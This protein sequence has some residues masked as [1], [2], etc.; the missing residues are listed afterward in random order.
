SSR[1]TGAESSREAATVFE[2]NHPDILFINPALL[3]LPF[4]QKVRAYRVSNPDLR[5]FQ[6]GPS[7]GDFPKEL[8]DARFEEERSFTDFQRLMTE[9]LPL[10]RTLRILVID[11]EPDIGTMVREFLERRVQPAFE[12]DYA[13]NGREGLDK[14]NR[15]RP[16]VLILDIK[17]PVK[18]GRQVYRELIEKEIKVPAI[19][20]F[21]A[22]SGDEV[23]EIRKIGNPAIVEKGSRQ[24]RLP[25]LLGLIK[26]KAYFG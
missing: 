3:S 8:F 19:I 21:D 13:A 23:T 7:V 22:I 1:L 12:V 4:T 26:K 5:V 25:E 18:D 15:R 20:F 9:H 11:D 6:I 2:K 14:I 17:M 16:D 10:S 24:S